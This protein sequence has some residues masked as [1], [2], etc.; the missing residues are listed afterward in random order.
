M[1]QNEKDNIKRMFVGCRVTGNAQDDLEDTSRRIGRLMP[2]AAQWRPEEEFHITLR[3]L[4]EMDLSKGFDRAKTQ[5]IELGLNIIA[6]TF[7]KIRLGVGEVGRFSETV[8]VGVDGSASALQKLHL[9]ASR[10]EHLAQGLGWPRPEHPF[11]PHITMGRYN[12]EYESTSQS[13]LDQQGLT[14]MPDL[15]LVSARGS[16]WIV[17]ELELMFTVQTWDGL[18]PRTQ[19]LTYGSPHSLGLTING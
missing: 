19:Y 13:D 16:T 15:E 3:P 8:W 17:K 10:T 14:P 18:T 9:M 6:R 7:P 12:R 2:Q 11:T 4:G 5:A 1:P